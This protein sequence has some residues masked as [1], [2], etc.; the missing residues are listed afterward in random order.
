[1]KVEGRGLKR[2]GG[3]RV[4]INILSLKERGCLIE[5]SLTLPR[6]LLATHLQLINAGA[7][8]FTS[9]VQTIVMEVTSFR[10]Q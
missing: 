4:G 3:G 2:G 9:Y 7:V 5:D 10:S 1:M 6:F 8:F